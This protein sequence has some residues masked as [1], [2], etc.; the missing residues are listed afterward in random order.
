M[1]NTAEWGTQDSLP[2]WNSAINDFQDNV[3]TNSW[4]AF[5]I[6]ATEDNTQIEIIPSN[7]IVSSTS[8]LDRYGNVTNGIFHAKGTP[9][10]ITL[11]KGQTYSA[12]QV[13][14][15][16]SKSL[17]G[18]RV[19]VL[20]ST[21][22]DIAITT[23]EDGLIAWNNDGTLTWLNPTDNTQVNQSDGNGGFT[24]SQW[25]NYAFDLIGDQLIPVDLIGNEYIVMR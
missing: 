2:L 16:P 13:Y 6:V 20:N 19:T 22:H 7:P 17:G 24:H 5:D 3:A 11:N 15:A 12:R 4:S 23:K 8:V 18:T 25:N 10:T 9:Y 14:K 21:G 1:D